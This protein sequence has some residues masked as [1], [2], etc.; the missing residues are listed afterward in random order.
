MHVLSVLL[1]L[2]RIRLKNDVALEGA[3]RFLHFLCEFVKGVQELV[4]LVALAH[5]PIGRVEFVN[6]GLVDVVDH[7]VQSDNSVFTDFTE[8]NFR[9]ILA[10]V[11]DTL[12]GTGATH[13]VDTLAAQFFFLT[14]KIEQKKIS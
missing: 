3:E 6:E 9:V 4:L 14:C 11:V 1:P 12:T 8:K 5:S 10:L 7:G 2:R 13:K